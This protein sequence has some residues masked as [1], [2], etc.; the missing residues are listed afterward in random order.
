MTKQVIIDDIRYDITVETFEN[1]MC[2]AKWT[3]SACQEVGAWAPI[4]V[5]P[6][7]AVDLAVVGLEL[8]HTIVHHNG[9]ARLVKHHHLTRRKHNQAIP[10]ADAPADSL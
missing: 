8:H 3:C 7:Q 5:E 2:Q 1:A 4:S 6:Q 10:D 9:S